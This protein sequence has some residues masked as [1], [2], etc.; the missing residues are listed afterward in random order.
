MSS[1]LRHKRSCKSIALANRLK[2]RKVDHAQSEAK[3]EEK[4]SSEDNSEHEELNDEKE[5][6]EEQKNPV[7][8]DEEEIQSQ[9]EE[10]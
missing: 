1:L 10:E 2:K 4:V 9:V 7:I 8:D 3:G 5:E 6:K